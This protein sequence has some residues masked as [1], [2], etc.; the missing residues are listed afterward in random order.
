[1]RGRERGSMA[2]KS[3]ERERWKEERVEGR[4]AQ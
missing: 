1:M 4:K 2:G 3:S